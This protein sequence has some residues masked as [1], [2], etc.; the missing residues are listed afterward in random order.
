LTVQSNPSNP[1]RIAV[2]FDM[3][4]VLVDSYDAHFESWRRLADQCGYEMTERQFAATFGRTSR[5]IIAELWSGGRLSDERIA[6][7]DDRKEAAYREILRER[8]P[9]MDGAVELIDA[10]RNAGIALAIG[11]SGPAENVEQ[12]VAGLNRRDAFDATVTRLDVT[13]GKPD[14]QVFQIAAD[15]LRLPPQRCA[16]VED[17]PAGIIAANAAGMKSIAL[18]SKGHDASELADAD[19]IV[20]SLREL[21]PQVIR[22]LIEA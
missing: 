7:L 9:A 18:V 10:L 14:P 4:G 20:K 1:D 6:E 21:S 2:V 5:E 22:E 19:L 8:F 13:R 12:V 11:S 3:D 16:V 15:R 17:A